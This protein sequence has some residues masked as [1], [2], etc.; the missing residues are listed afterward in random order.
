MVNTK[1]S[2]TNDSHGDHLGCNIC[3]CCRC[4]SVFWMKLLHSSSEL[5]YI[6]VWYWRDYCEEVAWLYGDAAK[7]KTGQ[8]CAPDVTLPYTKCILVYSSKDT[9]MFTVTSHCTLTT[10]QNAMFDTWCT[11]NIFIGCYYYMNRPMPAHI[12]YTSFNYC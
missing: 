9:G 3:E 5:D 2:C 10:A 11:T 8:S 6:Q 4:K 1:I 12:P 7:T